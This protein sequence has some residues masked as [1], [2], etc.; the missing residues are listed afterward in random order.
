MNIQVAARTDAGRKRKNNE[1]SILVW[2]ELP[3]VRFPLKAK[4]FRLKP[5]GAV[6][7]VAD[8]MGGAQAG[9][10]ASMLAIEAI[11]EMIE[12]ETF[13]SMAVPKMIDQIFLDA[14]TAMVQRV[15]DDRRTEGMGTTLVMGI[16]RNDQLH[17]GW[18]GDS[19]C[20]LFRPDTGLRCLSKDHSYVQLL[21]DQGVITYDDAFDHHNAHIITR[22]LMGIE[23]DDP[24]P[25]QLVH[26]I[27]E[28]DRFL[29][30]SDGLNSMLRDGTIEAL[31][32]SESD[33]TCCVNKCIDAA[34]Q[35]GGKDNVSVIIVDIQM[36]V[37]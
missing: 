9:E 18:L 15:L 37:N 30:C 11:E 19:R 35:A 34:N 36:D 16:L 28:G 22:S 17:I 24:K 5:V 33:P 27:A 32:R 25:D 13:S 29:Y 3:I 4:P 26:T 10:V 23:D 21:V 2:P 12:S 20:Y 14:Q 1:D 8:G 31:L 7:A 6:F